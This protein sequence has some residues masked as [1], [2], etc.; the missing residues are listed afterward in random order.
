MITKAGVDFIGVSVGA[1]IFNDRGEVFL[2]KRSQKARN[3]K[4]C[5]EAPGGAV[6]FGETH[7][8]AIKR[9]VKEEFG[10]EI[11]II[12]TLETADEILTKEKQHWVATA[13]ICKVSAG[14]DPK[15]ME[16]DKS[17]AIGWFSLD[18]LPKPMSYITQHNIETY[19]NSALF[20]T[21]TS[22]ES[23]RATSEEEKCK[24]LKLT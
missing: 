6:D 21:F 24:T 20:K 17:D 23:L 7:E 9:E 11:E 10:V 19:R 15:I 8:T 13:Y 3:E 4:G 1:L 12:K 16:P 18:N 22:E 5:W 2:N 14:Q